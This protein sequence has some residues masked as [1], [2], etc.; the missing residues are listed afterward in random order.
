MPT[1][2]IDQHL[3]IAF[4]HRDKSATRWIEGSCLVASRPDALFE[5]F[6]RAG[7]TISGAPSHQV[8][9]ELIDGTF[10]INARAVLDFCIS[11]RGSGVHGEWT[12]KESI[13]N[14]GEARQI[15]RKHGHAQVPTWSKGWA[16]SL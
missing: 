11:K 15:L 16:D 3:A 5:D 6:H 2:S 4:V 1:L 12:A 13:Q 7:W 9:D 14:I 8:H 10:V